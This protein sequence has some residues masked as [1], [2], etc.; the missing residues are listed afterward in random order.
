MATRDRTAEYLQ[1]RVARGARRNETNKL[2]DQDNAEVS[3]KPV[4]VEHL[5][6]FRSLER[7]IQEQMDDLEKKRKQHLKIDFSA[8][9]DEDAE[10]AAIE[11][12]QDIIDS[13][14]K[15]SE[16][17]IKE[18][19]EVYLADF[20]GSSSGPSDAELRI[21]R[22]VKM[23]LIHEVTELSTSYRDNQRKYLLEL[24]KQRGVRSRVNEHQDRVHETMERDAEV[25]RY[26]RQG[27]TQAQIDDILF[28]K[29]MVDER[30]KEY[31][32]IAQSINSIHEMFKDMNQLIID[33]GTILDRIDYNMTVALETMEK[34]N[35]QLHKAAELQK[36]GTYK[37]CVM[38]L[39]VLI[40]GFLLALL[41]KFVL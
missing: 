5:D 31:E 4:W 41:F 40:I 33:Q 24:K 35:E 39:V 10:E 19:D 15:Q 13:M 7:R 34:G 16:R 1:L 29:A 3:I 36:A 8:N 38:F 28:N 12:S 25:D 22:N 37:L 23:C 14:F 9:R 27:M 11:R 6:D 21:L 32:K 17:A 18:L 20:E 30:L 2:L 26:L